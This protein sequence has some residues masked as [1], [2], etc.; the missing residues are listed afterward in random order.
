MCHRDNDRAPIAVREK[1]PDARPVLT[2]CS[3]DVRQIREL[4]QKQGIWLQE[5]QIRMIRTCAG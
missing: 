3:P 1:F 2:P 4:L 5:K